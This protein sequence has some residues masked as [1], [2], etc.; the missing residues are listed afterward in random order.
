M[1]AQQ[2]VPILQD[3]A[4]LDGL[5][6]VC[7]VDA[8]TLLLFVEALSSLCAESSLE[9]AGLED[10]VRHSALVGFVHMHRAI[11]LTLK[12]QKQWIYS[13]LVQDRSLSRARAGLCT[14]IKEI[15]DGLASI[16]IATSSDGS[17]PS[18]DSAQ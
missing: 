18:G 4:R 3:V 8:L 5:T 9:P 16:A 15:G 14:P 7:L 2:R 17:C 13:S 1:V 12:Q 6:L 10:L 11:G